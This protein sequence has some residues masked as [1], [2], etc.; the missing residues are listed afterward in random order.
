VRSSTN[1]NA[2]TS[3]ANKTVNGYLIFILYSVFVLA[4]AL[5]SHL[6]EQLR[7][8]DAWTPFSSVVRFIGSTTY[9]IV[10]VFAGE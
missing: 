10:R 8:L 9:M 6:Y 2:E 5:S 3:G 7:V 4:R 1:G